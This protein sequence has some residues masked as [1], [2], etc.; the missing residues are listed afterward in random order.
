LRGFK[1]KRAGLGQT[2]RSDKKAGG[3][4]GGMGVEGKGSA[5]TEGQTEKRKGWL[6]SLAFV[7]E[8]G[9]KEKI[10]Q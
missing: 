8:P 5:D 4:R 7:G 6:D 2:T 1:P 3:G 9:G 10:G